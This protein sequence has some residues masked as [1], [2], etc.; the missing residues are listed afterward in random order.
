MT[1]EFPG[2]T[3]KALERVYQRRCQE[4]EESF[5]PEKVCLIVSLC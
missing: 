4:M 3:K 5:T 2:R 1:D